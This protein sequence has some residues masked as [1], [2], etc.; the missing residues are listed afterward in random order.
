MVEVG[1]PARSRPRVVEVRLPEGLRPG[2][3]EV[4]LFE[5]SSLGVVGMGEG[6]PG[7]GVLFKDH[8]AFLSNRGATVLISGLDGGQAIGSAG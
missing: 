8:G 5:W 2:V 3:V 1:F 4:G 7:R 6:K